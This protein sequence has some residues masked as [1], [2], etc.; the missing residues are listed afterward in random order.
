[1]GMGGDCSISSSHR[2]QDT[3]YRTGSLKYLR[4]YYGLLGIIHA[5]AT[6]IIKNLFYYCSFFFFRVFMNKTE[7]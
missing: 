2:I 4:I 5:W 1:M 3:G 7:P 6:D